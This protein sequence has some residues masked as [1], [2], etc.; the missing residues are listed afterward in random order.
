MCWG[1]AGGLYQ[2]GLLCLTHPHTEAPAVSTHAGIMFALQSVHLGPLHSHSRT[3]V[4]WV[5]FTMIHP[6]NSDARMGA[7]AIGKGDVSCSQ[8]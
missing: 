6:I 1:T 8:E 5:M 2:P 4:R 7:V 3:A